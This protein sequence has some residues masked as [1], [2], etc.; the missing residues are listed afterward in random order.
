MKRSEH[1]QQK[2]GT[3]RRRTHRP[4]LRAALVL[5]LVVTLIVMLV[6]WP[7]IRI[8]AIIAAIMYRVD[9]SIAVIDRRARHESAWPPSQSSSPPH[10]WTGSWSASGHWTSLRNSSCWAFPSGL[11]RSRTRW[12]QSM[13]S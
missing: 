11:Q 10:S 8:P 4:G 1:D 3:P 2:V 9:H 13:S 5:A 7:I 6:Q 12:K